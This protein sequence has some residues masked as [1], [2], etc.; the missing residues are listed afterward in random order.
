MRMSNG[1]VYKGAFKNGK[2]H[3]AGTCQFSTGALY[4]GEWRDDKPHGTGVLFSGSNELIECRF[5]KG[6][7]AGGRVKM[8]F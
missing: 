7:V 5:E 4:K 3:G 1:D 6:M 2:R 8:L